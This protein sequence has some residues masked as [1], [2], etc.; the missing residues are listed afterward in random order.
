MEDFSRMKRLLS[1]F[2]LALLSC[3]SLRSESALSIPENLTLQ[4]DHPR[5]IATD[6]AFSKMKEAIASGENEALSKMHR[7]YMDFAASCVEQRQPFEFQLSNSGRLLPISRKALGEM[8]ACAYAYRFSRER[9]YLER[10]VAVLTDVCAF[11]GWNPSHYLDVAE[12]ALGVAIAYDWLYEDLPETLRQDCERALREYLFDTAEKKPY[13]ERFKTK[14]NWGQVLNGA[15]ASACIAL[16]DKEPERSRALLQRAFSDI[17]LAVETCYAPD[18]IF[19]EGPMYWD[20]GTS[21]QL[22]FIE[23]LQSAFGSD[24]GLSLAKGFDKSAQF[25]VF[26]MGNIG[27]AYNY[28]DFRSMRSSI[29]ALWFFADRFQDSGIICREYRTV[30]ENTKYRLRDRLG[31]LYILQASRCRIGGL[32]EPGSR[33]FSGNGPCPLVMAR[34]GWGRADIYLGAKGGMASN[35][36]SHMDAGSFV[37]EDRGIRWANEVTI[38]AYEDTENLMKSLGGSL[39]KRDQASLRWKMYGYNNAQHSTLTLNGKDHICTAMATLVETYDSPERMGGLFDLSAIFAGEAKRVSRSLC[40][41][42]GDHLEVIDFIAAPD[43]AA[44]QVRWNMVTDAL[45]SVT[46][47]GVILSA[48]DKKMLLH[49]EGCRVD[50]TDRIPLPM[51]VPA[52]FS[53]F[54]EQKQPVAGFSFTLPAGKTVTVTTTL[55]RKL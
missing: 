48:D 38:P 41:V 27:K 16:W 55:R 33:I 8:S 49:A 50:Y 37:Y 6:R 35:G 13:R 12:M 25:M 18:G 30:V 39:W 5:L 9:K 51:D 36:H 44:V 11:P 54:Y 32:K 19:P 14:G 21:Y 42:D 7:T 4:A 3:V 43:T 17:Q 24:F 20:Y 1:L 46:D 53:P 28:A 22:V 45:T 23:A 29:P 15:L 10:A 47:E 2:L 40:I 31:F 52:A 34:T 26:A